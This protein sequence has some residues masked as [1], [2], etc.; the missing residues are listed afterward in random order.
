VIRRSAHAAPASPSVD[1]TAGL[2][3]FGAVC[4]ALFNRERTGTGEHIDISLFDALFCSN[5]F[6]YQAALN[7][8]AD[9]VEVWYH[10]VHATRDG[11]VTANVGPDMRA[12]QNVCKAM[13]REDLLNDPRFDTQEHVNANAHAAADLVSDWLATLTSKEAQAALDAHHVPCAPVLTVDQA[14]RQP[15]VLERELTV[16]VNDP[17]LGELRTMNSAFRYTHAT[18]GVSGPAPR[19]GEHNETVLKE[20]LGYDEQAINTLNEQGVLQT[21]DR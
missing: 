10:P 13:K 5:D 8:A 19:L 6:T 9:D 12:W 11:Y 2:T 7:P 17:V 1:T 3:A 20:V 18:V 4:A 16:P 14:V 15:Q 21:R